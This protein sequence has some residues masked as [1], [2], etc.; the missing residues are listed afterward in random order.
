MGLQ[1]RWHVENILLLLVLMI[2]LVSPSWSL[3]A[4]SGVFAFYSVHV[5]LIWLA[6]FWKLIPVYEW[7]VERFVVKQDIC[8]NETGVY[9]KITNTIVNSI[10]DIFNFRKKKFFWGGGLKTQGQSN[11]NAIRTKEDAPILREAGFLG[12]VTPPCKE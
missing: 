9:A 8:H 12:H 4:W 6:L 10:V 11:A 3:A 7:C 1:K 2:E 5:G